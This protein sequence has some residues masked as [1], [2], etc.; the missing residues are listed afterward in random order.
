MSLTK[1]LVNDMV[2]VGINAG[3]RHRVFLVRFYDSTGI[4]YFPPFDPFGHHF[5]LGDCVHMTYSSPDSV[6][7]D[8]HFFWRET[9]PYKVV[10]FGREGFQPVLHLGLPSWSAA[11]GPPPPIQWNPLTRGE[12]V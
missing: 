3:P 4:L 2:R 6:K 5:R 9:K 7:P 8:S 1:I 12:S 11:E 10:G